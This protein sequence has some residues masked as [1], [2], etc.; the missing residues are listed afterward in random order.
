M[1]RALLIGAVAGV[2]GGNDDEGIGGNWNKE[3]QAGR[4]GVVLRRE[5]VTRVL[6]EGKTGT[7]EEELVA[8]ECF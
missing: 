6:F 2:M 4:P 7:V 5:Q 3:E 8:G 1:L